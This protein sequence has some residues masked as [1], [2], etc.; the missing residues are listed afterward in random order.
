MK[1]LKI[2]SGIVL[3]LF[4][5][6]AFF[7]YWI[8]SEIDSVLDFFEKEESASSEME[9]IYTGDLFR[10]GIKNCDAYIDRDGWVKT[11]NIPKLLS[12]CSTQSFS[13]EGPYVKVRL[14]RTFF[15]AGGGCVGGDW[16][17][18]DGS[19]WEKWNPENISLIEEVWPSSKEVLEELGGYWENGM[20]YV[21][22][23]GKPGDFSYDIEIEEIEERGHA[24]SVTLTTS[25]GWELYQTDD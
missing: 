21:T 22:V 6:G 25:E 12:S 15:S 3:G 7:I 24:Y 16:R 8:N 9:E 18:Q 20:H 5:V 2:I 11:I 17:T 4:I 14:C 1:V 13:E 19:V 23:H 10:L